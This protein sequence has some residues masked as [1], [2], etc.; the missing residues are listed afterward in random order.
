MEIVAVV[1]GRNRRV[2]ARV[3]KR[4]NPDRIGK[5]VAHY[6]ASEREKSAPE[7]FRVV[8]VDKDPTSNDYHWIFRLR[9]APED[10]DFSGVNASKGN[11][12]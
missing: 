9:Y 4:N 5:M 7:G 12:V 10:K 2:Y 11:R 6:M 1:V 8:G 3:Y